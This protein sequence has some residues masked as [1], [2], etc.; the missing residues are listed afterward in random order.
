MEIKPKY[1]KYYTVTV[2]ANGGEFKNGQSS[3][4]FEVL[5]SQTLNDFY[6]ESQTESFVTK[7]VMFLILLEPPQME[8]DQA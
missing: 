2:E 5:E 7:K 6:S 3:Y 8:R 4:S 1:E